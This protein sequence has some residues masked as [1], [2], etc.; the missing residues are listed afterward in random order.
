MLKV[1]PEVAI[2]ATE[3]FALR[4]WALSGRVPAVWGVD[5][6]PTMLARVTAGCWRG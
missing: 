1:T 4:A 6:G 2:A 5:P 3:A